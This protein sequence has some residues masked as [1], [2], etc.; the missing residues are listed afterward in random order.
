MEIEKPRFS[1]YNRRHNRNEFI[2][3]NSGNTTGK[4]AIYVEEK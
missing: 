3:I 2:Q 4:T 1:A